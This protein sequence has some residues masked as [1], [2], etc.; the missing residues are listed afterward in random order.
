MLIRVQMKAESSLNE[1]NVCLGQSSSRAVHIHWWYSVTWSRGTHRDDGVQT[2]ALTVTSTC[3]DSSVSHCWMKLSSP[4][5]LPV[6]RPSQSLSTHKLLL[7]LL[8][9]LWIIRTQLILSTQTPSS[10]LSQ[11]SPL[12]SDERR[13]QRTEVINQCLQRLPSSAVSQ[14]SSTSSIKTSRDFSPVQTTSGA[15]VE[16]S[17]FLSA[18]MLTCWTEA[19]RPA[20]T[21]SIRSVDSAHFTQVHSG[22]KVLS[23]AVTKMNWSAV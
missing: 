20:D 12:P 5:H 16:R 14:W 11:R 3:C 6:T 21:L 7:L 1:L 19:H 4:L 10:S 17:C 15:A 23:R 18:L 13:R 8:H 22:N 2:A 9:P